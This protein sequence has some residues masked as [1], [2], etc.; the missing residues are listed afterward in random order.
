MAKLQAQLEQLL[1][2][3]GPMTATEAA[4][5]LGRNRSNV[6]AVLSND[7]TFSKIGRRG[8]NVVYA[9]TTF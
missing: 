8:A 5:K 4:R 9:L 3:A 1:A 7:P 6:S 2:A